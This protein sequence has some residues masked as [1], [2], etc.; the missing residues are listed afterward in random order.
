[1]LITALI[2]TELI[3]H[4]CFCYWFNYP[5][6]AFANYLYKK[7]PQKFN[8]C[9]NKALKGTDFSAIFLFQECFFFSLEFPYSSTDYRTFSLHMHTNKNYSLLCHYQFISSELFRIAYCWYKLFIRFYSRTESMFFLH[10]FSAPSLLIQSVHTSSNFS[11]AT[12]THTFMHTYANGTPFANS[13]QPFQSICFDAGSFF[14]HNQYQYPF[15]ITRA[16]LQQ[17]TE[18]CMQ[19]S[20]VYCCNF[21]PRVATTTAVA[22]TAHLIESIVA[23]S[24]QSW[25]HFQSAD[26]ICW[27]LKCNKV[28]LITKLTCGEFDNFWTAS[29]VATRPERGSVSSA[30]VRFKQNFLF[31]FKVI[32]HK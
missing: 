26:A 4:K 17:V 32:S 8:D 1:M 16:V 18:T 2:I 14:Q 27:Q 19:H 9:S 7:V 22:L 5:G 24:D 30:L 31:F 10:K 11:L 15:G 20:S 12:H 29:E 3:Q 13:L 25:G 28:N 23:S 6:A 21:A